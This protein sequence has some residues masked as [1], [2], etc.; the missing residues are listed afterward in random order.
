VR[1]RGPV[2]GNCG[3]HED[4]RIGMKL[5]LEWV[6]SLIGILALVNLVF[7]FGCGGGGDGA[8]PPR[9]AISG[10]VELSGGSASVIDVILTLSGDAS[11]TTQPDSS[12]CYS[13]S[14]LSGGNYS[15]TA[16]LANYSFSPT[17]YSYAPLNSD[18]MNQGFRGFYLQISCRRSLPDYYVPGDTIRVTLVIDVDESND[19]NAFIIKDYAPSGWTITSSS[20]AFNNFDSHTGEVKWVFYGRDVADMEI[21]YE[22]SIPSSASGS[23]T[24]TGEVLYNDPQGNHTTK[25]ISGDNTLGA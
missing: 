12:G 17:S 7:A 11:A 2:S 14:N 9:Y 6:K 25:T 1:I 10:T 4:W 20:P 19:P 3:S 16:S 23:N 22:V 21:T 5:N 18:Q 13:F 24:F 8:P 15:V